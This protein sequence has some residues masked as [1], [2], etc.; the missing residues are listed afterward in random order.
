MGIGALCES[1]RLASTREKGKGPKEFLSYYATKFNTVEIDSTYYVT[2]SVSTVNGWYE[3]TP[4]DFLFAAKV[5]QVITHE[6]VPLG[7]EKELDEFV[8]TMGL[9][10]RGRRLRSSRQMNHVKDRVAKM[11]RQE[12][13]ARLEILNVKLK[14]LHPE[15][16]N[17]DTP[18]SLDS[19]DVFERNAI[20]RTLGIRV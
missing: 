6:K 8:Q 17:G 1:S 13:E 4:S 12:L 3:K 16:L 11:S 9:T 19:E 2:P 14:L 7:C 15:A 20:M 10:A 5:P 18:E